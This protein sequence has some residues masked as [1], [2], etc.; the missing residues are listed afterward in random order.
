MLRS[1][2]TT[3]IRAFAVMR[4]APA[5]GSRT[6]TVVPDPGRALHANA[7]AVLLDDPVDGRETETRA[8]A[9]GREERI[10][11]AIQSVHRD[12]D[13]LVHD[14]DLDP[15]LLGLFLVSA[16]GKRL[17]RRLVR[18]GVA[19]I[20]SRPPFGMA[21]AALSTRFQSTWRSCSGSARSA[22]PGSTTARHAHPRGPHRLE[23]AQDPVH[24]IAE[25]DLG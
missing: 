8:A 13:A 23:H 7:P 1:S 9:L 3:R 10:E 24:R 15:V 22:R 16:S 12:A 21:C 5:R 20:S 14:G 25:R 19:R 17:L 6:R 18:A 2:S 4:G 11:D